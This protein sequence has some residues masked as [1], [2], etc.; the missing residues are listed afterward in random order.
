MKLGVAATI[1]LAFSLFLLFGSLASV[2]GETSFEV[3]STYLTVYR[4]GLVHCKQE[5][6][7]DVLIAEITMPM[8][9]E[10]PQNILLLDENMTVVDYKI[11]EKNV[12]AY[13]LG[14]SSILI[15]Y[16]TQ[17]LTKKEAEVWT[18]T[19]NY[20]YNLTVVL[21]L[22]STVIYLSKSPIAIE[23]KENS[24]TLSLSPG[25]WEVSYI[26]PALTPDEFLDPTDKNDGAS[27]QLPLAYLA[28]GAAL[29]VAVIVFALLL[30]GRKRVPNVEK[31]LKAH[32]QLAREDQAVIR[33]LAE[34]E[35]KA[36]EAEIREK[37]P[38]MPRTSLWRL[39]RRLERL[40]IVE[41]KKIGLENQV[42]LTK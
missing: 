25:S 21:P 16:D 34:K 39:V 20:Q 18:L 11:S 32:P 31:I 38:D 6:S 13:T 7:L 24:I 42:E 29:A 36:F 15:D 8:L 26:L 1:F 3:Q 17:V 23:T 10:A 2:L 5:I 19:T 14:A 28:V 22:N 41:I 30:H 4:D 27:S 33:F 35:G 9:S 40:E 12:T 37:F